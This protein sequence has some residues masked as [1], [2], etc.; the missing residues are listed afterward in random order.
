MEGLARIDFR[1]GHLGKRP[2]PV[3]M[4]I[5]WDRLDNVAVASGHR[6]EFRSES[7][8]AR[9]CADKGN[10]VRTYTLAAEAVRE[11]PSTERLR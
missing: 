1:S 4:T 2:S 9:D 6:Y 10:G 3:P 8:S 11:S 5:R 7:G